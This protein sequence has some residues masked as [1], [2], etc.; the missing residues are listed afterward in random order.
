M[1][2]FKR[3]AIERSVKVLTVS[4]KNTIKNLVSKA[5]DRIDGIPGQEGDFEQKAI[6]VGATS[7]EFRQMVTDEYFKRRTTVK[8]RD[9]A[10]ES[11]EAYKRRALRESME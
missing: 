7:E 5:V 11:I 2:E 3:R 4:D 6:A 8:Q 1:D 10:G 9:L